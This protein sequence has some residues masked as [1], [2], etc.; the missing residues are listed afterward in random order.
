MVFF[1]YY[2]TRECLLRKGTFNNNQGYVSDTLPIAKYARIATRIIHPSK[3]TVYILLTTCT[4]Y[5]CRVNIPDIKNTKS[6]RYS[7]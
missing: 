2:N 1:I 7:R 4:S 6:K 5:T 3:V